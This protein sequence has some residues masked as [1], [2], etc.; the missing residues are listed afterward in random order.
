M[1][2]L[3]ASR[4]AAPSSF[5]M[6]LF[7]GT[8]AL[9]GAIHAAPPLKAETPTALLREARGVA[10]S[11]EDRAE[12]STALNPIVVA[13]IAIDPSGAQETMKLFPKL[14]QRL[15]YLT[16]LAA[17]YA[18]T[19]NVAGTERI[20]ADIVVEDQSSRPGRLAAANA[21]GQLAMAY[22]NKGN[23]LEAFRTLERLKE[24]TKLEPVAIVGDVTANLV[25]A[26]A[27]QGD[28]QG[29][30][31]TALSIAGENPYPLMRIIGDRGRNGKIREAQD[32]IASLDD[33]A[34]RYAQ[35]GVMQ[36]QIHQGRLIEA[37]VTASAIKPGH[38]KASALL[39][40]AAYHLE[41][42]GKPLALTLLQEAET[43]AR[44]TVNK[45]TRADILWRIAAKTAMTGD[46]ARAIS[47]AKSIEQDGHRRSTIHDIAKTQA[48]HGE[49]AGAFNTAGLLKQSPVTQDMTG[50]HYE[51]ALSDIL[52]EMVKAGQGKEANATAATFQDPDIRRPRLFSA[53]A[54]A[55]ADLGKLKE[56]KEAL[57]LAETEAQRN[58]RRKELRQ[59]ADRMRLGHAPADH[60][61][62]E[63][64]LKTGDD[65]QEGLSAIA[66]ALARKGELSGALAAADQLNHASQKRELL[67][68]IGAVH[69]RIG[70]KEDTLGWARNLTS[71]SEKVFAL[72]GIA[73]A[74][75]QGPTQR[76]AK[77]ASVA[78]PWQP[79][80]P[81]QHSP[82][83][84]AYN[85]TAA[86]AR[87][88]S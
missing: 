41:H 72:V 29:A 39:E 71:P 70:R 59:L 6:L 20:Y 56:A 37:Q 47:I 9:N 46:S 80:T 48:T 61:R 78:I 79:G 64:L 8:L 38:A 23:L 1:R 3:T 50:S 28:I 40:L 26:Q 27:K 66:K 21:L 45:W 17:H 19:G 68:Q 43:S 83:R 5:L 86:R 84:A 30:I 62:L 63:E 10:A 53:I 65:I 34:Q 81:S 42:G 87:C 85:L 11:I 32:I 36:A 33:G 55:Y 12:R 74:L 7:F 16:A 49:F 69:V 4:I 22:A 77:P 15:N 67:K 60:M 54:T 14:P 24:R 73:T 44:A 76:K 88:I 35:W 82:E 13:Q 52:I 58:A 51:T 57:A 25:D 2:D 75:S 18:K 31:K